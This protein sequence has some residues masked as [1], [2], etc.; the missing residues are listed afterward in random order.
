MGKIPFPEAV[1]SKLGSIQ[2]IWRGWGVGG[3]EERISGA[4]V[5]AEV[6]GGRKS[7]RSDRLTGVSKDRVQSLRQGR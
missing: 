2:E 1:T 3:G 5:C 7:S 6:V 4:K